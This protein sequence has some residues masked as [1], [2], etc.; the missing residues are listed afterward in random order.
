MTT[1]PALLFTVTHITLFPLLPSFPHRLGFRHLETIFGM[2]L[3]VMAIAMGI[4]FVQ[5][6]IPSRQVAMG[7]VPTV[8]VSAAYPYL[9]GHNGCMGSQPC[10]A[11]YIKQC[12]P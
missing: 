5:A 8:S 7:F 4:N 3:G 9:V 2:L 1:D 11:M 6:D 10:M 12:Q